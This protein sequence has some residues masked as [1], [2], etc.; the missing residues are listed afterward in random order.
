MALIRQAGHVPHYKSSKDEKWHT[1]LEEPT[2][3]VAVAGGD[4][5]VAK[6]ARRLIRSDIPLAILPLGTAN[7][8]FKTL[9]PPSSIEDLIAGWTSGQRRSCDL[10]SA[11]GP[12][13]KTCFIESFGIGLLARIISAHAGR[14]FS[15]EEGAEICRTYPVR[16]LK[17][18]LD[19]QD[20]SGAYVLLEAMNT[21]FIGANFSLAPEALPDDRFLDLV[22]LGSEERERFIAYLASRTGNLP[23]PPL[24]PV[25]KGEHVHVEF[26]GCDLHVDDEVW[27][28]K[29]F[30]S[31]PSPSVVDVNVDGS[32]LE[33]LIPL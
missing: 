8:V 15:V 3:L 31:F 16:P 21:R 10:G 4:G 30:S 32:A 25:R 23:A 11:R 24:F 14:A 5:T 19:G 18:I 7:N 22:L 12:W 27:R 29:D 33:F 13:G 6:V 28:D 17:V 26:Q 1:V 2:D 9:Y 20:L